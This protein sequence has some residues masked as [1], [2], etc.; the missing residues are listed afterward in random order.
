MTHFHAHGFAPLDR[1]P[2]L[3]KPKYGDGAP[4]LEFA[5]L[6]AMIPDTPLVRASLEHLKPKLP[7][8]TLHHSYRAFLHAAAIATVQFPEWQW[9]KES[10]FLACMFHDLGCTKEN[11]RATK[12][13]FEFYGAFLAREFLIKSS[14]EDGASPSQ[15]TLDLADSVAEAI[16]RHTNFIEGK[17]TTHGQMIQLGTL[18]DNI[19]STPTW[20]HPTTASAIVEAYPRHGWTHCFGAAMQDEVAVKPWSHTSFFNVEK[21]WDKVEANPIAKPFEEREAKLGI[22]I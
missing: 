21:I 13:S 5:Q 11:I 17:I 6:K 3:L 16:C 18:F 19:G 10:F 12:L 15:N 2:A 14:T 1:N 7:K 8:E 20:I 9:D 4:P 22:K